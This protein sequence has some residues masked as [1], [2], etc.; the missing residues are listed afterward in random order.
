MAGSRRSR[1]HALP[2]VGKDPGCVWLLVDEGGREVVA[3]CQPGF[4]DLG[5]PGGHL[6]QGPW[7]GVGW[8]SQLTPG[9]EKPPL[10]GPSALPLPTLTSSSHFPPS[11]ERKEGP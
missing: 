8:G 2:P 4:P 6:L 3:Q 5:L 1:V 10:A 11:L 7:M 9:S